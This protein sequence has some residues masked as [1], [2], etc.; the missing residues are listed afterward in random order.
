MELAQALVLYQWITMEWVDQVVRFQTE[1]DVVGVGT[2]EAE[3]GVAVVLEA[4][5]SLEC[6]D[7]VGTEHP[8]LRHVTRDLHT[9]NPTE[10]DT[11]MTMTT[12]SRHLLLPSPTAIAGG[13][14]VKEGVADIRTRIEDILTRTEAVISL[15][16]VTTILEDNNSNTTGT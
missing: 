5:P 6:V 11:L 12:I 4:T 16:E 13:M 1:A 10:N 15:E 7:R 2:L 14:A 8:L 9:R 3:E